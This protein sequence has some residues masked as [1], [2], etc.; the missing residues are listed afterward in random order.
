MPVRRHVEAHADL[1]DGAG[2][3]LQRAGDVGRHLDRNDL[4]A[5]RLAGDR[6]ASLRGVRRHAG[7]PRHR[8]E[9]VDEVGDVVG[10]HVE[11]RPAARL[12]VEGR[13]R[14]P[15]LVAGAHEEGGAGRPAR[16]SRPRRSAGGRSGARRRERCPARSRRGGPSSRAAST[17]RL[18]SS[19]RDA[20]RLLGIDVLAGGERL[21][22]DLD[23]RLRHGEVDD[24]L[25][26][27][28]GEQRVDAR[29]RQPEL[30][31][32]APPPRRASRR[33]A[34]GCRGSESSSRPSGRRRRCCRSR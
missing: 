15:A 23:M 27:R 3:E 10:R 29:R 6:R 11:H 25:D 16:R 21:Q 31:R 33:R 19:K 22:A 5:S 12:V 9:Q 32:R 18:P 30:R 17:S 34:R 26:R 2:D 20:E 7:D 14:V 24:D 13:V 4:A 8:P 1:H 28:I